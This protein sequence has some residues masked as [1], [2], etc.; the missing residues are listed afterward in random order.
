MKVKYQKG[1]MIE[2]DYTCDSLCVLNV[3]YEVGSQTCKK[4]CW[5]PIKF[6]F[7]LVMDNTGGYGTKN[8]IYK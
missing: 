7:Y 1:K 5:V 8:A 2:V 4:I 3:V 6:R